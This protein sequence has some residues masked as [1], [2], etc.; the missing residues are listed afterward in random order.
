MRTNIGTKNVLFAV[1]VEYRL[2][3]NHLP[4]KITVCFVQIALKSDLL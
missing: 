2:L 4:Q 3:A 1:L